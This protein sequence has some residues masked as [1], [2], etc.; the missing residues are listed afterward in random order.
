MPEQADRVLELLKE[1][2]ACQS[3][4][5][6]SAGALELVANKLT[7]AGF[8]CERI[9]NNAVENLWA[10]HGSGEPSIVL[11]GHIDVV[12]PGDEA[13]WS[14][15]PF[16]PVE[17][18]GK[19]YG[20]G[21]TDMKGGV[22]ALTTAAIDF[23]TAN[24]EHP[25]TLALAL[26]SDEEGAA[27][28]G[29]AHVVATLKERGQKFT[30][31]LVGEPSSYEEFGDTLRVG[32]RG[33][34]AGKLTVSGQQ[35]HVAYPLRNRNPIPILN[36]IIAK[37]Y[38]RKF[39]PPGEDVEATL[40]EVVHLH[41]DAGAS[42][43]VPATATATFA[44]RHTAQDSV[45]E[46]KAWVAEVCHGCEYQLEWAQGSKPYFTGADCEIAQAMTAIIREVTGRTPQPSVGGGTS[47]GRFLVD[48]CEQVV[49]FGS[50]GLTMHQVDEHIEIAQL[51]PLT[52]IYQA[53]LGRLLDPPSKAS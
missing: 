3:I 14:S 11:C 51:A 5:P 49:E 21:T 13:A 29:I 19:L 45:D 48:V 36:E 9:N 37:L 46:L 28:D 40:F 42:N 2:V 7:A 30:Y 43:V 6:K 10:T 16:V 39:T 8:T 52:Q 44:I 47:D 31:G 1:L 22:A 26:T 20:R 23:V 35:G 50:V 38:A 27:I 12:P 4:T 32:R 18:D 33:S 41:A 17:K 24:P 53:T 25:G 34:L 15:D